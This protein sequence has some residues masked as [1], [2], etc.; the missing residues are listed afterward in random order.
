MKHFFIHFF[1]SWAK[2]CLHSPLILIN[3]FFL[4]S[5]TLDVALAA[6]AFALVFA[7]H[8]RLFRTAQVPGLSADLTAALGESQESV[9]RSWL[10]FVSNRVR[11]EDGCW[12]WFW[13]WC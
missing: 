13:C 6:G 8:S 1:Q 7:E 4:F 11:G 12:W 3:S 10:F 2:V 9:K 5:P